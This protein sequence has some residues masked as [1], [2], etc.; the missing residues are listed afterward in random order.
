MSKEK[1]LLS[2]IKDIKDVEIAFKDL[3]ADNLNIFR[4]A[5][6]VKQEIK[7]SRVLAYILDPNGSHGLKD[8][9]IKEL[10]SDESILNSKKIPLNTLIKLSMADL[11]DIV[12]R[13][14]DMRIDIL[15]TS[16]L[17][18]I[19]IAIENKVDASEGKNQLSGYKNKI[20]TDVRFAN[21]QKIFL[22]LTPQA[23]D[24]SDDDW[25]AIG[26][27]NISDAIEAVIEKNKSM[28]TDVKLVL[29]H[30]L[31]LVRRSILNEVDED[32]RTACQNL[33]LKHKTIF[34]EIRKIT[35]EN[36][37]TKDAIQQ[38]LKFNH[39]VLVEKNSNSRWLSFYPTEFDKK[40]PNVDLNRKYNGTE[41]PISFFYQFYDDRIK[42]VIEVGPMNDLV[43]RGK[44]VK[45]LFKNI[46]GQEKQAKSDV[47]SRVWTKT[48]KLDE[49]DLSDLEP[50]S[51]Q[52]HMETLLATANKDKVIEKILL[53]INEVF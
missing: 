36:T 38:F 41:K 21:Y 22:Y 39:D 8:A 20:N 23:D 17:N 51:I 14:E 16:K 4:I 3:L 2:L 37:N 50:E 13:C 44:L 33:Y 24:P 46:T 43:K 40:T 5:G 30:Y 25:I 52:N 6:L 47:Y 32:F 42:L 45:S 10:M 49:F 19:V 29:G 27:K 12:V 31:E 9:F 26:Y 34:D 1:Q 35:D 15:A 53:S 18:K 28:R 11:D 7:H 48:H